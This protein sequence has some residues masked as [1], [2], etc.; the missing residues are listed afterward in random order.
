MPVHVY[1]YCSINFLLTHIIFTKAILLY[2]R[3]WDRSSCAMESDIIVEGF[4]AESSEATQLA[5]FEVP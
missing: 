1:I 2:Y 5:A 4:V 3:N